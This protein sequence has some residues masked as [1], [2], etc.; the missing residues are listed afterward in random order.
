MCEVCVRCERPYGN[1][2]CCQLCNISHCIKCTRNCD[3]CQNAVLCGD[4]EICYECM[5]LIEENNKKE[6]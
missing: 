2:Y 4:C 5:I 6:E 3:M 1:E